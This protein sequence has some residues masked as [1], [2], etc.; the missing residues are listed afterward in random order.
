MEEYLTDTNEVS[1]PRTHPEMDK[2]ASHRYRYSCERAQ[3]SKLV[4]TALS[5]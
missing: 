5:S 3:M 2:A 4:A 1:V